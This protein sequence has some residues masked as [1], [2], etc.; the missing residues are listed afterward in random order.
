MYVQQYGESDTVYLMDTQK[1]A[2]AIA[3]SCCRKCFHLKLFVYYS[4]M[5]F[6]YC[7]GSFI[8]FTFTLISVGYVIFNF[9]CLFSINTN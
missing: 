5:C 7:F 1:T 9:A 2:D 4:I 3:G 6:D 8:S